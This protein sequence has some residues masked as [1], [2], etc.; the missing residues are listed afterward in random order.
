M[1][2]NYQHLLFLPF[3]NRENRLV[4]QGFE[5]GNVPSEAGNV[6]KKVEGSK[7]NPKAGEDEA[8]KMSKMYKDKGKPSKTE[9][10]YF[11]KN[12]LESNEI[13]SLPSLLQNE[14]ANGRAI[15]A[16][17]SDTPEVLT[18]LS[19]DKDARVR[20]SV[21]LNSN[22]PSEVLTSLSQDKDGIVRAYVARNPNTPSEVLTSL[23][24]D[25][26]EIVRETASNPDNPPKIRFR[27]SDDWD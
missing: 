20:R 24:Q 3:T 18:S 16:D 8:E 4:F 21:A 14:D 1:K 6:G 11:N 17:N 23:L 25:K 27:L 10:I 5:G 19:L 15:L 7:I 12:I 9:Q 26:D 13:T 22:T 2:T